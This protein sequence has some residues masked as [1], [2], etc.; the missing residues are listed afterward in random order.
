MTET[1]EVPHSSW[2]RERLE[3]GMTQ[4][5]IADAWEAESGYRVS[6]TAIAMAVHRDEIETAGGLAADGP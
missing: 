6:R 1:P 2:L 4:Q 3:R 5:E